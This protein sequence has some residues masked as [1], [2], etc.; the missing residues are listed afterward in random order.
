MLAPEDLPAKHARVMRVVDPS[1]PTPPA[2]APVPI[3]PPSAPSES[4]T[5]QSNDTKVDAFSQDYTS[6]SDSPPEASD[7]G[8]N[9][10]AAKPKSE[11]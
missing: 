1:A 3:A 10:V 2:P 5:S 4:S 7:D 8:W 6:D 9:V 11:I